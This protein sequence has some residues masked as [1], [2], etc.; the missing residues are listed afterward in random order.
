MKTMKKS[1][2]LT[3]ALLMITGMVAFSQNTEI[4]EVNIKDYSAKKQN[5]KKDSKLNTYVIERDMPGA[6]YL[7][8]T[9]LKEVSQ[10]SN[11]V[12]KEQGPEIEWL[13]SYVTTY[14]IYCVYKAVDKEILKKHAQKA[15]FPINSISQLATVIS[16]ATATAMVHQ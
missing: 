8:E 11:A 12:I 3:V 2:S 13:H 9:Q 4:A 6:G 15:E 10:L 7:T 1:I 5:M 14:K 16:P